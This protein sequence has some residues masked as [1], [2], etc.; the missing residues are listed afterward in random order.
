MRIDGSRGRDGYRWIM[1][2]RL[3]IGRERRK[4]AYRWIKREGMQIG[5]S[6][7]KGCI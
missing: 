1:E 6:W 4:N 7:K 2:D 5:R 3:L